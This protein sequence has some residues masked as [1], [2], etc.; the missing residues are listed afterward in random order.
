[1]GGN[2]EHWPLWDRV[3]PSEAKHRPSCDPAIHFWAYTWECKRVSKRDLHTRVHSCTAHYSES[4]GAA[5]V[6]ASGWWEAKGVHPRSGTL[7]DLKRRETLTLL[8]H[9]RTLGTLC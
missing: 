8:H 7:L 2:A 9:G 3:G 4:V 6:S 5:R 1:M